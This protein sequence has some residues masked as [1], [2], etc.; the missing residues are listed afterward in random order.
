M[1]IAAGGCWRRGEGFGNK[2]LYTTSI[3]G[4]SE[5]LLE[6]G[7]RISHTVGLLTLECLGRKELETFGQNVA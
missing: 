2:S 6:L 1:K 7:S 5:A 4:R 3:A